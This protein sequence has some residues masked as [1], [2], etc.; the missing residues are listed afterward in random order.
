[1]Y[2]TLF[3]EIK[4]YSILDILRSGKSNDFNYKEFE[5]MKFLQ[6]EFNYKNDN[7]QINDN[8]RFNN[9]DINKDIDEEPEIK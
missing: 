9:I 5:R 8:K 6:Q 3:P 1:M 4:K 2:N 7:N